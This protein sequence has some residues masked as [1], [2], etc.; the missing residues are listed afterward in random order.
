[1]LAPA[2]EAEVAEA[3]AAAAAARRP[4]EIAGG[5]SRAGLGRPVQAADT[6]STAGLS[7]IARYEPA[8]LTLV[9]RAGTPLAEIEAALAAEN[10]RLAFEP[11]DHRALLRTAGAPTIGGVVACAASGPRRIQA[12]ACRDLLLGV[13]FVTGE[14]KAVK[15]GGRV[16]KNVTGYDLVK[17]LC[18]SHG[19]LGVLTEVTFKLEAVP[20]ATVTLALD[21]LDEPRAV[22]AL[23]AALGSPFGVTG[24]AHLPADAAPEGTALTLI[25]TEGM[26]EQA[27]YRA[28]RIAGRLAA[29]GVARELDRAAADR[30][31]RAVRDAE[32]LADGDAPVWRV[33]LK[34]S[35]APA[36]LAAIRQVHRATAFFDWGGGLLWL[37][38][39]DGG[40]DAGAAAIR[41][42]TARRGG[43][44]TLVRAPDAV[45]AAVPVFEPEPAAVARLS[46]GL[47][48]R[49]D[50][51][52]ILNPGRMVA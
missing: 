49:F 25:R 29:F 18:G 36:V 20:E 15:S 37:R 17:L 3:V 1:M 45:R 24:A 16:M 7:G 14:G 22:A 4:L 50:P 34:P 26:A 21:G 33:S 6:L 9:A 32:P 51:A 46:A 8:G 10:Q 52:G 19:T 11:I 41:T 5:R 43:H 39:E 38:V 48:A 44:A 27:A 23:A 31:W 13:R 47:R 2:T 40:G 30:L 42:E 12:G 35:D 28:R